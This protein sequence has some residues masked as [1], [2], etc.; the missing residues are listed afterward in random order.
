MSGPEKPKVI[1]EEWDD[2]RV[3]SFLFLSPYDTQTDPD[4]HVL[5]KAYQSMREEDFKRLVD[6]FAAAGRNVNA[7]DAQGR[8][9]LDTLSEHRHGKAYAD[10][11]RAQGGRLSAEIQLR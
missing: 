6:F 7:R 4:Y 9:L 10:A 11:L 5:I 1:G 3:K 2:E 8:T